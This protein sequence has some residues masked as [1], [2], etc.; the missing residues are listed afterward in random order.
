MKIATNDLAELCKSDNETGKLDVFSIEEAFKFCEKVAKGH[1][2]NFPVS[3]I[4]IPKNVRKHFYS[5][6]A[7]SRVADD[8]ADEFIHK[9]GKN[10]ALN[11]LENY[12]K[13][14]IE[15][16]FPKKNKSI[17]GNKNNSKNKI[18]NPIFLALNETIKKFNIPIN[19]FKNLLKAFK[20]DINFQQPNDFTELFS[21]C[22]NSANPI[23]E[24]LLRIFDEYN[25]ITL[26]YSNNICTA[27]Q[28]INF[29]QDLS[30]DLR[31]K[32]C[33]IPKSIIKKYFKNNFDFEVFAKN[34]NAKKEIKNIV[35]AN[36]EAF[37]NI[38]KQICYR[39]EIAMKE[40]KKLLKYLKKNDANSLRFKLELHLIIFGGEI[41]LKKIKRKKEKIFYE[42]VKIFW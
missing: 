8:I 25:I 38:I 36:K 11:L 31:Q 37:N 12:E 33:Y 10:E 5:I 30:V 27:L 41:I 3:S 42:R 22:E 18:S 23:G 16:Y 9:N 34:S 4:L 21:Y 19:P 7:F 17:E 24:L 14:L 15:L 39:A 40:G 26:N 20:T 28:L 13:N 6:Y 32:R 1:Y 35:S 29:W 2:E